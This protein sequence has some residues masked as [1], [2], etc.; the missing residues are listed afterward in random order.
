MLEFIRTIKELIKQNKEFFDNTIYI[1]HEY[2]VYHYRFIIP[3]LPMHPVA[4][5][6]I[7][8]LYRIL[9]PLFTFLYLLTSNGI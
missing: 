4:L 8:R 2:L 5:G 3:V 1:E 9:K 7:L 6:Y